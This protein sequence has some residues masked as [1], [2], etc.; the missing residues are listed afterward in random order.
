MPQYCTLEQ[1]KAA[2]A[3]PSSNMVND[4]AI[5]DLID[6]ISRAIDEACDTQFFASTQTRHYTAEY[7]WALL[8]DDLLALTSLR[9]DADGDGVYELTWSA[10][11]FLLSPLNAQS[12]STPRPYWQVATRISGA[13]IFPIGV[14][15]GV[16]IVGSWGFSTTPPSQV[17]IVAIRES[18]H[19]FHAIRSPYGSGGP[20]AAEQAIPPVGLSRNSL[21]LLAPFRNTNRWRYSGTHL[22]MAHY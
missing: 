14:P 10:S 9:T 18:V 21:A 2:L 13:R 3:L 12:S 16:E 1:V 15:A 4:L 11:D 6:A 22:M 8:V 7:P 19:H 5:D 17:E 20:G